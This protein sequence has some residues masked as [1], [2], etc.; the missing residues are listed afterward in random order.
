MNKSDQINELAAALS[1]FQGEITNPAFSRT[2]TVQPRDQSKRAYTFRYTEL[3]APVRS[4]PQRPVQNGLSLAA[5]RHRQRNEVG[6]KPCCSTSRGSTSA[7]R[8]HSASRSVPRD[9]LC[10]FVH[11]KVRAFAILGLVGDGTTT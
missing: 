11:E 5:T 4:R 3:S 2:V 9:R 1:A 8:S 7:V 6:S 10:R